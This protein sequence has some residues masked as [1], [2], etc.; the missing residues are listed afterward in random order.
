VNIESLVLLLFVSNVLLFFKYF[1]ANIMNS[2]CLEQVGEDH[3]LQCSFYVS[4]MLN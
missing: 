2:F 4:E 1:M 3:S